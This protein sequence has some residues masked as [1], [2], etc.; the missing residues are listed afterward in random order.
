MRPNNIYKTLTAAKKAGQKKFAVLIDPDE[1]RL[2]NFDQI[3]LLAA[4]GHVD[5]FFIGG[6]LIVN[7]E[8][9]RCVRHIKSH[10]KVPIILFPGNT[11]QISPFADGILLLSLISGRNPDLLIGKQVVAAPYLKKSSLE[12]LATGYMLVD[13]GKP[14]AVSYISNTQPIP[15]DKP[16]IAV[17]TAMAGEMLGLKLLYMDAGSGARQPVSNTMIRQVSQNTDIPLI[18][19][20]GIRTPAQAEERLAAG[21][22]MLVIGNAIEKDPDQLVH[23]ARVI[24]NF[25]LQANEILK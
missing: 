10:S 2:E 25:N 9:E 13:G 4:A 16:D 20:G 17:C 23:F 6:S 11:Y 7:N 5:Y 8:L 18:V 14:T 3:L 12:I 24:H 1:M 21:A 22:D 15:A 19:G